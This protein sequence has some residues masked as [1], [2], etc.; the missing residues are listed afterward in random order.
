M[1]MKD[2]PRLTVL[3]IGLIEMLIGKTLDHQIRALP[4]VEGVARVGLGDCS[5]AGEPQRQML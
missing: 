3:I 2:D 4:K 1:N 5:E